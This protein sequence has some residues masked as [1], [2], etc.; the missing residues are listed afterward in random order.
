MTEPQVKKV[1]VAST[2]SV[3]VALLLSFFFGPLGMVYSTIV[4]G[5]IMFILCLIVAAVTLGF[6]LFLMWPIC[7]IWAA[8]AAAGYNKRLMASV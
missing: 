1:V 6:G 8:V 3:G 5:L 7:M 4:G 2:K